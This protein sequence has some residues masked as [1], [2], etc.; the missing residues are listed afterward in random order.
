M[1]P[2]PRM[3]LFL[4]LVVGTSL[5]GSLFPILQKD[6]L[7]TAKELRFDEFY[8]KPHE[9]PKTEKVAGNGF[10]EYRIGKLTARFTES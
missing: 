6:L 5:V 4:S 3:R 9:K 10:A 1:S 7:F 2:F 8:A